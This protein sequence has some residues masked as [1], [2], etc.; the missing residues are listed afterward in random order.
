MTLTL[1]VTCTT[2]TF[3][4]LQQLNNDPNSPSSASLIGTTGTATS[5]TSTTTPNTKVIVEGIAVAEDG[6]S[7]ES[8]VDVV[9]ENGAPHDGVSSA[10]VRHK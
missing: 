5:V 10:Q 1:N 8:V 3:A 4:P 7:H 9:S 2:P 6:A